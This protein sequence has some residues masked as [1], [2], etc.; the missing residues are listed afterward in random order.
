[1]SSAMI[2][3]EAARQAAVDRLDLPSK[4]WDERLQR[5]AARA[6]EVAAT[7]IGAISVVDRARQWMIAKRGPVADEVPREISFCAQVIHQPG[8]PLVVTDASRDPRFATNP[9]VAHAPFVRFYIGIPLVDRAG[10]PLGALCVIDHQARDRLPD[11]YELAA[12]A[13][14]AERIMA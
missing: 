6:A 14:E 12:L 13:R 10:Y 2:A 8:E 4:R 7:P 9:A 5:I 1:M 11:L 3:E